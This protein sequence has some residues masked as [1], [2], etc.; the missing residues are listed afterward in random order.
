MTSVP[1]GRSTR[2]ISRHAAA[3]SSTLRMPNPIVA[4]STLASRKGIRIASPRMRS[5]AEPRILPLPICSIA[6]EKSTPTTRFARCG[7]LVAASARSAV[8]VQRSRTISRPLNCN[9]STA[10]RRHRLSSPALSRWF[11]RSYRPAIASNMPE[12]RAASFAGALPAGIDRDRGDH[13][14]QDANVSVEVEG[15]LHVRQIGRAHERLL[16]DEEARNRGN[17]YEVHGP[18]AGGKSEQ[19]QAHDRHGVHHARDPE[20]PRNPESDGNRLQLLPAIDVEIL[21]RI[22]HIE[23]AHPD[24]D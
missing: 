16:I 12:M 3:G 20:R 11:S 6:A 24:R 9:T 13:E 23:S 17:T 22:E 1:P 19:R 21:A 4:A 8:P 14:I 18:E 5:T 15:E 7:P 10:R 2:A